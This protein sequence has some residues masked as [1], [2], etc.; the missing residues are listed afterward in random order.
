MIRNLV[1]IVMCFVVLGATGGLVV[2]KHYSN[3]QLFSASLF[4]NPESC[5]DEGDHE[6]NCYEETEILK[7]TNPLHSTYQKT[8][9]KHSTDLISVDFN[10]LLA[11]QA[12]FP[13]TIYH[14]KIYPHKI[15]LREFLQVFII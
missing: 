6:D 3:G 4:S 13:N 7:I 14:P 10:I 9:V 1:N 2:S 8:L 11:E 12:V 15:P 5:C